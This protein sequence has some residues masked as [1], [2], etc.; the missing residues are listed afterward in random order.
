MVLGDSI[1]QVTDDCVRVLDESL[2]V[3]DDSREGLL[4]IKV[5]ENGNIVVLFVGIITDI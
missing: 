3:L 1:L 5:V 2:H 4:Y